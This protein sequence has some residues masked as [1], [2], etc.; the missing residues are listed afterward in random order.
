MSKYEI[1]MKAK[2]NLFQAMILIITV[3]F[4]IS[5]DNE[6]SDTTPP[7]INL[8]SPKEGAV[9]LIGDGYGIHLDMKLS[10]N[11]M[12]SSYKIDIHSNFDGHEH[13]RSDEESTVPF[14]FQKSWAVNQKNANIHHH[15]IVI[16]ENA[17]PGNY[18]LMVYCTDKAGNES[19]AARAIILSHDGESGEQH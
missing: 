10:D 2:N 15:E 9:L 1:N 4:F 19:Y 5:C 12:L 16:P 14:N 11:E 18:H 3:L 17:T 7:T 13:S 8:I 6:N